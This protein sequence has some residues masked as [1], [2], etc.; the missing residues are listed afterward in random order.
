ML[1]GEDGTSQSRLTSGGKLPDM[2]RY[3]SLG[4]THTDTFDAKC[5]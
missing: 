4:I 5:R 2:M 3:R 1:S